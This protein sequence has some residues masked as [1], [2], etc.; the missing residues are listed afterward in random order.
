MFWGI[1]QP[2]GL[3]DSSRWSQT[4]GKRGNWPSAPWRGARHRVRSSKSGHRFRVQS[5][6]LAYR[7][8]SLRF[9]LRLLSDNPF[10]L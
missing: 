1:R 6:W 7:R 4:T 8:S 10:G 3:Q 9:D 5:D 2:A